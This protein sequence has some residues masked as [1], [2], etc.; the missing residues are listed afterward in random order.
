MTIEEG[1]MVAAGMKGKLQRIESKQY[2]KAISVDP[3]GSQTTVNGMEENIK[4][5]REDLEREDLCLYAVCT[6][7]LYNLKTDWV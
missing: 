1:W 2:L 7:T 5:L 6:V 3:T 4:N